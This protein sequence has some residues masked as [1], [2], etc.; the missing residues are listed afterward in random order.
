MFTGTVT[1]VYFLFFYLLFAVL[2]DDCYSQGLYCCCLFLLPSPMPSLSF[3][4]LFHSSLAFASC[5]HWSL[6]LLWHSIYLFDSCP[7]F[8]TF[9]FPFYVR[10]VFSDHVLF[11]LFFLGANAMPP[12]PKKPRWPPAWVTPHWVPDPPADESRYKRKRTLFLSVF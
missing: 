6:T 4:G 3:A 5:C 11:A 10:T 7:P 2:V 9:L 1:Y 12:Q 8:L